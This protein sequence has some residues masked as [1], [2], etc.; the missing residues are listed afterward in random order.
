[1]LIISAL[2]ENDITRIVLLTDSGYSDNVADPRV[3]Y[4]QELEAMAGVQAYS[5]IA[6]NVRCQVALVGLILLRQ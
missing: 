4:Q 1:M 2:Q 5:V 3:D 6:M